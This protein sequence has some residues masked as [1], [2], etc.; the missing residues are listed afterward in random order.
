MFD[1]EKSKKRLFYGLF[2]HFHFSISYDRKIK[3]TKYI[4]CIDCGEWI[5]VDQNDVRSY[6]CEEC[7]KQHRMEW[8][9]EYQRNLMRK[10]REK[11]NSAYL[12]AIFSTSI[13]GLF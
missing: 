11:I 10:K 5:E 2:R 12:N 1:L 9:R 6:R 7:E 13:N 4:Q 3:K 8:K